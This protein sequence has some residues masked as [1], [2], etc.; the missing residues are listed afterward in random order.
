[1]KRDFF[2]ISL[3]L[4]S[5]ICISQSAS[6]STFYYKVK[7]VAQSGKGTVYVS[8][9]NSPSNYDYKESSE[10]VVSGTGLKPGSSSAGVSAF[11]FAKANTSYK[12][13]GFGSSAGATNYGTNN[14]YNWSGTATSKD[15]DKPTGPTTIYA[16]FSQPKVTAPSAVTLARITDPSATIEGSV[17]FTVSEADDVN[18]FS[19]TASGEGFSLNGNSSLS[20]NQYTVF[21]KFVVGGR[22]GSQVGTITLTSAYDTGKTVSGTHASVNITAPVDLEPLFSVPTPDRIETDVDVAKPITITPV[23]FVTTTS[24]ATWTASISGTDA[25]AFALTSST[26]AGGVCEVTFTPT[27]VRDN[28]AATLTL[29]ASYP[30]TGGS[31]THT[32]TV[33]LTGRGR[34]PVAAYVYLN[35]QDNIS[36][37][38]ALQKSEVGTQSFTISSDKVGTLSYIKTDPNDVFTYSVSGSTLT[39][40]CSS[41]IPGYFT[42][43]IAVSGVSTLNGTTCSAIV[44]LTATIKPSIKTYAGHSQIT[45]EWDAVAS[46][47]QYK[48][49]RDNNLI[50]TLSS[51]Q[52]TYIDNNGGNQLNTLTNYQYEV[53]AIVGGREISTGNTIKKTSVITSIDAPYFGLQIKAPDPN[54]DNNKILNTVN[55]N[56]TLEHCFSSTSPFFDYLFILDDNKS[57]CYVYVKSGSS[58]TLDAIKSFNPKTTAYKP[59]RDD[60]NGKKYYFTGVCLGAF[61]GSS[62]ETEG[63]V[64]FDGKNA[65]TIDIYLDNCGITTLSKSTQITAEQ[66]I[67][68]SLSQPWHRGGSSVFAFMSSQGGHGSAGSASAPL[69]GTFHLRGTNKLVGATGCSFK[70]NS[71]I[72]SGAPH[73]LSS[74]AIG[75]RPTDESQTTTLNFNDFWID[76]TKRT[77]GKLSLT[78]TVDNASA[79]DIGNKQGIVNFDGGQYKFASTYFPGLSRSETSYNA[80][81]CISYRKYQYSKMGLTLIV[82]GFGSDMYDG[83]VN[84]YDGSFTTYGVTDDAVTSGVYTTK[85]DLRF[86]ES[87]IINGGTFGGRVYC[88]TGI[89]HG[90]NPKNTAGDQ[91]CLIEVEKESWTS[92]DNGTVELDMSDINGGDFSGY[93]P[94]HDKD[95]T[96]PQGEQIYGNKSLNLGSDGL[97]HVYL[98]T[99]TIDPEDAEKCLI[100]ETQYREWYAVIPEITARSSGISIT[101]GGD[102]EV[103]KE[104]GSNLSSKIK[105]SHLAYFEMDKYAKENAVIVDRDLGTIDDITIASDHSNVQN[106]DPY[107]LEFGIYMLKTFESNKWYTFVP[108]F[109]IAK[110]YVIESNGVFNPNGRTGS[111]LESARTAFLKEQGKANFQMAYN[112]Y[113]NI[114]PNDWKNASAANLITI[115]NLHSNTKYHPIEII[116]YNGTNADEAHFYLYEALNDGVWDK[117]ANGENYSANWDFVTPTAPKSYNK[118]EEGT[119][120]T[121]TA[122]VLM[123]APK[124]IDDGIDLSI[125]HTKTYALNFPS[126]KSED[127]WT[128]KYIIFEGYGPQTLFGKADQSDF[129]LTP[130][131]VPAGKAQLGGNYT[132]ANYTTNNELYRH[133]TSTNLFVK[134]TGSK[135]IYPGEA[136]LMLHT[137]E[138]MRIASVSREGVVR[139]NNTNE[140]TTGLPTIADNKLLVFAEKGMINIQAFAQQ[141][142]SVYA[143]NGVKIYCGEM[144][145]GESKSVVATAG[146]YIIRSNEQTAKL[147]V[148]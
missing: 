16:T 76:G 138:S 71:T 51:S 43:S 33:S 28:Y 48:I 145:D 31:I 61:T 91:L 78:S 132:F 19:A 122:P 49:Y 110:I 56:L 140:E 41:S 128:G 2:R 80:S 7:A 14:P 139:F 30:A 79:I 133:N 69:T 98:S 95:E 32:E 104:A 11:I 15:K 92:N 126:S 64:F 8:D 109:D 97:L 44:S 77:N 57:S 83:Y 130:A 72:T 74:A 60:Y 96:N 68:G 21:F 20:G 102:V 37:S 52:T 13:K 62:D 101:E 90:A 103:G 53:I 65:T 89:S 118:R 131:D 88:C 114:M 113:G 99:E 40:N 107:T 24:S 146:V 9:N 93:N 143:A 117:V 87:T 135:T 70:T 100:D 121:F 94:Y 67:L 144:N 54:R 148:P 134:E 141:Q 137:G 34:Q 59:A 12:F 46:A 106:N 81:M 86:P 105:Y 4:F 119:I 108:P 3:A 5:I 73:P 10:A 55:R 25:A 129:F 136:F 147:I 36:Y 125:S 17:V 75:I 84:V 23:D 63:F 66:G 39:V 45:L 115:L 18:D 22:N 58:Y 124:L 127:Y 26:P 47:T 112:V 38:Y 29:T 6:A 82:Y 42:G 85:Q 111:E 35:D 116:P 120:T 123:Q 1:M 27:E 142:V 50:S